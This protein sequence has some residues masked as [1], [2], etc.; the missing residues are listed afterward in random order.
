[1]TAHASRTVAL[2]PTGHAPTRRFWDVVRGVVDDVASQVRKPDAVRRVAELAPG[3]RTLG[4]ACDVTET[5]LVATDVALHRLSGS[6]IAEQW[7]RWAWEQVAQVRWDDEAHM[8]TV[9]GML[10]WMPSRTVVEFD[11]R[12]PLVD[13]ALE[14]VAWTRQ[15]DTRVALEHGDVRVIVRRQP[16]TDRMYWFVHPGPGVDVDAPAARAELDRAIAWLRADTGL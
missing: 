15:L 7:S 9:A 14:R 12:V 6:G 3:E 2:P 1:M 13:L 10:P 8:L 16:S 11:R 4:H 5:S